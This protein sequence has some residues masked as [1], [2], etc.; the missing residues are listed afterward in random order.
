MDNNSIAPPPSHPKQTTTM[1]MS[2]ARAAL[3]QLCGIFLITS[4]DALTATVVTAN[5]ATNIASAFAG[6]EPDEAKLKSVIQ[7]TAPSLGQADVD[8]M[9][10]A[11]TR[12]WAAVTHTMTAP[13][14]KRP[15]FE[16]VP[17]FVS[18]QP[19]ITPTVAHAPAPPAAAKTKTP[20]VQHPH[21]NQQLHQHHQ[22]MQQQQ[23]QQHRRPVK[24]SSSSRKPGRTTA[25]PSATTLPA[26]AVYAGQGDL[27]EPT[28]LPQPYERH[29]FNVSSL[30]ANPKRLYDVYNIPS[31]AANS[32]IQAVAS[33]TTD[34]Q[35]QTSLALSVSKRL[36]AATDKIQTKITTRR[37]LGIRYE[38]GLPGP[39]AYTLPDVRQ[40]L[41]PRFIPDIF[42]ANKRKIKNWDLPGPG[43]YDVKPEPAARIP[44]MS[45]R[46]DDVQFANEKA[47]PPPGPGSYEALPIIGRE[48]RK[49]AM[50]SRTE[51]AET[52]RLK[53]TGSIPGPGMYNV[54][55]T[56]WQRTQKMSFPKK[57]VDVG[58]DASPGPAAYKA[59]NRTLEFTSK[60]E[61]A[62]TLIG[63]CPP[64]LRATRGARMKKLIPS[65]GITTTTQNKKKEE[66]QQIHRNNNNNNNNNVGVTYE[67]VKTDDSLFLT[68]ILRGDGGDVSVLISMGTFTQDASTS[69]K[70]NE[71]VEEEVRVA[72]IMTVSD[73][74][75]I[76]NKVR[77][78]SISEGNSNKT[79]I[80]CIVSSYN[81]NNN[82]KQVCSNSN[83]VDDV[84]DDDHPPFIAV[85]RKM[86]SGG[87]ATDD[88]HSY[89]VSRTDVIM[90][91]FVLHVGLRASSSLVRNLDKAVV[92]MIAVWAFVCFAVAVLVAM[93][94]I[95]F[96]RSLLP[97]IKSLDS[98]HTLHHHHHHPIHNDH[99]NSSSMTSIEMM[100]ANSG[101]IVSSSI[102]TTNSNNSAQ[103]AN[104][105]H[106]APTTSRF[107][108]VYQIRS[109]MVTTLDLIRDYLEYIPP[110]HFSRTH[111][112]PVQKCPPQRRHAAVAVLNLSHTHSSI[113]AGAATFLGRQDEAFA[114]A[115][116][117]VVAH[118]GSVLRIFGDRMLTAFN[119]ATP[120]DAPALC[121]VRMCIDLPLPSCSE[122]LGFTTGVAVGELVCGDFGCDGLRG[123]G[124]VGRAMG[125]A[126]LLQRLA[127]ENAAT[128]F[129]TGEVYAECASFVGTEFDVLLHDVVVYGKG[130]GVA[131]D[132]VSEFVV[133][134]EVFPAEQQQPHPSHQNRR[135]SPLRRNTNSI[136]MGGSLSMSSSSSHSSAPSPPEGGG[137]TMMTAAVALNVA[138]IDAAVSMSRTGDPRE[139]DALLSSLQQEQE[140]VTTSTTGNNN[141]NSNN[142]T[143]TANNN[144]HFSITQLERL[145]RLSDVLSRIRLVVV[146]HNNNNNNNN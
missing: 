52:Q 17:S 80:S 70:A 135:S 67:L 43:M 88:H 73:N 47:H 97:I 36:A 68:M 35:Q 6:V 78:S 123:L 109:E 140:E 90:E 139:V 2:T 126:L 125:E 28:E 69:S 141:N 81:N 8:D 20:I 107:T 38:D 92:S 16:E 23:K 132:A 46:L 84:C 29:I 34:T 117:C 101:S 59:G 116:S 39:G 55:R 113:A 111:F 64:K 119:A 133:C 72:V 57:L 12:N 110:V 58:K 65:N 138:A 108:E 22:H 112:S 4:H 83:N 13:T 100:S 32:T 99:L 11:V 71:E 102:M 121:A 105:F 31:A 93:S 85:K 104:A 18:K 51:Y 74:T 86:N 145:K 41:G 130:A 53:T 27:P 37:F 114:Q 146:C 7:S 136:M 96:R 98:I 54:T 129:V 14:S 3:Q 79:S 94:T 49:P 75:F 134:V 25:Q 21:Q 122:T 48:G 15:R 26:T 137:L 5:L 61:N 127:S 40:K 115:Q 66:K 50:A 89:Y 33:T 56:M 1:N 30:I 42:D 91:R 10:R 24:P 19:L 63:P 9:A 118:N 77:S 143:T 45:Q 62:G 103:G 82:N 106:D 142:H 120:C 124:V 76:I 95:M 87:D 44:S 144:N 131:P 60:V 128:H